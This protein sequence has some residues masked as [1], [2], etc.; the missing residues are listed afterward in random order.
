MPASSSDQPF[1]ALRVGFLSQSA[2][3]FGGCAVTIRMECQTLPVGEL[4]SGSRIYGMPILQR[5]FSW[6]SNE[7]GF[8]M[9]FSQHFTIRRI[10][11]LTIG[12]I[13]SAS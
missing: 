1:S 3:R 13:F 8:S 11:Q 9:T 6:T 5:P 4:L 10:D 7:A 12:I 2:V